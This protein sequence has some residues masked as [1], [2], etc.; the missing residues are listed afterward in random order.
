MQITRLAMKERQQLAKRWRP[1][2][3]WLSSACSVRNDLFVNEVLCS[4]WKLMCCDCFLKVTRLVLKNRQLTRR[5]PETRHSFEVNEVFFTYRI[6]DNFS[7]LNN[8]HWKSKENSWCNFGCIFN[9]ILIIS[10]ISMFLLHSVVE[11]KS[12][13]RA[14]TRVWEAR[15]A[16]AE[17]NLDPKLISLFN[18]VLFTFAR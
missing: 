6:F 5:W 18:V 8:R 15:T 11:H 13:R 10:M 14:A 12:R 9:V 1:T 2:R 7:C 17:C 16:H 3:Q 4:S